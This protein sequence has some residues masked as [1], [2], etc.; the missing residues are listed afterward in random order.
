V[1]R[2]IRL[3][4]KFATKAARSR[5]ATATGHQQLSFAETERA[6]CF[7]TPCFPIADLPRQF[8]A[9][10]T[11]AEFIRRRVRIGK[12]AVELL[13]SGQAEVRAGIFA[14][15]RHRQ[16]HQV[17]IPA[18]RLRLDFLGWQAAMGEAKQGMSVL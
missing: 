17:M 7:D 8:P 1:W 9:S 16:S 4:V 5:Y 15:R 2:A 13:D 3:R 14:A 18:L 11:G 6:V 12:I 10:L